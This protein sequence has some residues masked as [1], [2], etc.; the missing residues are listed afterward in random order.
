MTIDVLSSI[1]ILPSRQNF[2]CGSAWH[3]AKRNRRVE[4]NETGK[5]FFGALFGGYKQSDFSREEYPGELLTFT[6]E[7]NVHIRMRA[8]RR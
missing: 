4:V 5:S 8:P 6:H 1:D 2:Y 7:R 3:E